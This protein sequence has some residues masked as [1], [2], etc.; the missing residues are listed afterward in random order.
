MYSTIFDMLTGRVITD[1]VQSQKV[2][3]ATLIT[4]RACAA[5]RGHSVIVEDYGTRKCYRVTPSGHIW[6]APKT[7]ERPNFDADRE[8]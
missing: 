6:C 5:Q 4:A 1:G 3:D 8:D 7:W 2:C